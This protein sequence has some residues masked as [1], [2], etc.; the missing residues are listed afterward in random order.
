[1]TGAPHFLFLFLDGVGIGDDDP[2]TNPFF[3]V[4]LKHIKKIFGGIP[5]KGNPSMQ[6]GTTFIQPCDALLGVEGLPQSG[7][8]QVTLFTGVNAAQAIGMHF[9]PYPHSQ[10]RPILEDKN[11]FK[12]LKSLGAEVHFANAFPRQFFE[13]VESGQ[14]RLSATT[15]S[16]IMSGVPLCTA[17]SLRSGD[18]I[19][20]DITAER[21]DS[22]LGYSDIKPMMPF[23]SGKILRRIADKHD[24][25]MFEFFLT[26]K[27]GHDQN[28][29]MAEKVLR[30][31][32]EFLGGI[33]EDGL[34]NLTIL[35]SSD[36]GNVEDLSVRTHTLNSSLTAVA[37]EHVDFFKGKLESIVDITPAIVELFKK[38]IA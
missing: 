11:I 28:K 34:R 15:L 9:G 5:S 20:A 38:R 24:F 26:D 2:E 33:V 27:A 17:D 12:S 31:F 29:A 7:T 36:H 22:N 21:W 13:Y 37:G 10:I 3:S 19:S 23:D 4:D 25:T 30:T 18:G 6:N 32:D 1:M 8:G 16:C 35:I 14:R